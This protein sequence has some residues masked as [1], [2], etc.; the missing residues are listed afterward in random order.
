MWL[1]Q[2]S[3]QSLVVMR[4]VCVCVCVRVCM[5]ADFVVIK[6]KTLKES[7]RLV[8]GCYVCVNW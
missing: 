2:L 4:S 8:V 6:K 3:V 5:H 1:K 7:I